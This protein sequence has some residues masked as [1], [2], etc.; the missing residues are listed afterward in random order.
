[1]TDHSTHPPARIDTNGNGNGDGPWWSRIIFRY[2]VGTAFAAVLMW[3][4]LYRIDGMLAALHEEHQILMFYGRANCLNL[5][6]LAVPD[7]REFAVA[8]CQPPTALSD[9]ASSSAS[10]GFR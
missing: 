1:M 3:A 2:G 7:E 10:Q 9:N 4:L 8:T 6:R 5:A